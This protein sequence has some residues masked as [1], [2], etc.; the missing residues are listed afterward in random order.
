MMLVALG[1]LGPAEVMEEL[2]HPLDVPARERDQADARGELHGA[3]LRTSV[4]AFPAESSLLLQH[5][6]QVDDSHGIEVWCDIDRV[7]LT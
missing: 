3:T 2:P 6:E 4:A 7:E 5:R 1:R